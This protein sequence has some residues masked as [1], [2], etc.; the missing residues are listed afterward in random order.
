MSTHSALRYKSALKVTGSAVYEAEV[1]AAGMLHAALVEASISC[2]DVLS[3]DLA[4]AIDL[5]GFAAAVSY[6]DTE[7]L[8]PSPATALIRERAIH[9]AGQPVALV[10]ADT[11]QAA[12]EAARAIRVSTQARPAVTALARALDKSFAPAMVGRFPAELVVVTRPGHWLMPISSSEI[13][14]KPLSTIIT[15]WNRTRSSAGGRKAKP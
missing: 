2:G 7:V 12:K 15:P 9:F 13:D 10:T 8:Q 6:A 4:Q 11:L 5:P 1:P 3:V 14:T